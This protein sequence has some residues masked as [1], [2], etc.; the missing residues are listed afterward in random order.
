MSESR[1]QGHTRGASEDQRAELQVPV[2]RDGHRR[3]FCKIGPPD[4]PSPSSNIMMVI[5]NFNKLV[6]I[7]NGVVW[8][9]PLHA[10]F[11]LAI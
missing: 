8:Y 3:T 5:V 4:F 10:V 6:S 2:D 9:S 1:Y 7:I 11:Q